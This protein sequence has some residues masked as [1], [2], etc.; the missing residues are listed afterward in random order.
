[1][2]AATL[3][4]IGC[5]DNTDDGTPSADTV[6]QNI[7]SSAITVDSITLMWEA[8]IDTDGYQGVTISAEPAAGNLAQVARVDAPETHF[9]VTGLA[10]NS[11]YTFTIRTRYSAAGKNNTITITESSAMGTDLQNIRVSDVTSYSVMLAWEPPVQQ[12]G[13]QGVTINAEPP[14]SAPVLVDSPTTTAHITGLNPTADYVFTLTSR[15]SAASINTSVRIDS[16]ITLS[17]QLTN[18]TISDIGDTFVTISWQNPTDTT[19]YRGAMIS[20][21]PTPPAASNIATAQLQDATATMLLVTG[22][23]A[24][25]SYVFTL[26]GVYDIAAKNADPVSTAT[27]MTLAPNPIDVDN[28]LLIDISTLEQLYNVRYNLDLSDGGR[29]KTAT[30][31]VGMQCGVGQNRACVGYELTHSLDFTDSTNYDGSIADAMRNWLPNAAADS[32]GATITDTAAALNAGWEPIGPFATRFVGN[33]H[34]I[35]NLYIRRAGDVGL[36]SSSSAAAVIH[37]VGVVDAA[38]YGSSGND[39]IGVLVGQNEGAVISSSATGSASGGSGGDTVGGLVGENDG[40]ITASYAAVA[41]TAIGGDFDVVGGLVGRNNAIITASYA[42]GTADNPGAGSS[43]NSGGLV[44][45][46]TDASA[47]I[48]ASYATGIADGWAASG[49]QIGSLTGRR[50]DGALTASYG[51][52]LRASGTGIGVNDSGDRPSHSTVAA[53]TGTGGAGRLLAPNAAD[54]TN[55]AVGA[56]W[57]DA[58]HATLDAWDFGTDTQPPAL[59]YADYDGDGTEYGCG[60][61]TGSI[62]TMPSTIPDGSGGT[63]PVICGQTLLPGQ[64]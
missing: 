58:S 1:M 42:T 19:E 4:L 27:V 32:S 38:L 56:A 54:T 53:G 40:T 49:G 26:T 21:L 16:F 60:T 29:Y 63:I 10:L 5:P 61:T 34:T 13:Y 33:G 48:V 50:N 18:I 37:S 7:S 55:R 31:D 52:G 17:N 12:N 62:A 39:H 3:V 24:E 44:G 20:A 23:R 6:V 8:P 28:D 9:V 36:F 46:H 59:Q 30:N 35:S 57:H 2:L 14:L 47:R 41:T 25:D 64:R 45:W 43:G 22:L 51:F 15:Y 11:E